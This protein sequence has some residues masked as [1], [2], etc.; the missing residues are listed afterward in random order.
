MQDNL[1]KEIYEWIKALAVA[2]TVVF[3][4]KFFI[5]DIMAIDGIS[6][7]PTLHHKD[8]VFVNIAGFKM[9]QPKHN[10]VVIFTPSIEPDYYYVKRIIGIPG[11]TVT[12]KSGK[13][14]V[15]DVLLNEEYLS[16]GTYTSPDMTIEVPEGKVFV[17]G[18]N[19]GS[20]EDSRDPR[21]GPITIESIKGSVEFRLFPFDKIQKIS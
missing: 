17:L 14:Y 16:P 21:L 8:R 3:L 7:E 6:M 18:D 11:D 12:I 13:V 19:R 5:F 20:S 9:G 15:N 4:L 2:L 1:K 10:D